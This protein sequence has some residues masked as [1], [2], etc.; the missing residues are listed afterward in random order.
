M[1]KYLSQEWLDEGK[2]L[3]QEFPERP[4]ATARM[5]YV[6]TGGPEGDVKYYQVIDNGKMIESKLGEDADAEF[7]LTLT[8]DDSVK[9]QK[10]ELDANAAF[11]Q[12]RMKVTG[13]M[14]KLMSLMPLTQSPEYKAI[15]E[16][17]REKTDF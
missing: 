16:K 5:Q 12:G 2:E 13:N 6:V 3:A 14:G 17:V 4:G 11:M 9:V 1:S 10:G 7:T 15:Q 8:Y